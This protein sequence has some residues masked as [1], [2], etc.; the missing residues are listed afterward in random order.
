MC[1]FLDNYY[2]YS[3]SDGHGYDGSKS[4]GELFQ[5]SL[6]LTAFIFSAVISLVIT[7][8]TVSYQALRAATSNP[9]D[10]LRYE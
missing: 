8:L 2:P 5:A 3:D 6:T 10:S 1:P 4:Y 7:L 9:V